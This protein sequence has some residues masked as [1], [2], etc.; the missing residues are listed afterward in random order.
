MQLALQFLRIIE[1]SFASPSACKLN[2]SLSKEGRKNDMAD[3]SGPRR[4]GKSG[5]NRRLGQATS[6][7]PEK[8][9]KRD[10]NLSRRSPS[11]PWPKGDVEHLLKPTLLRWKQQ[12][13]HMVLIYS[14][15]RHWRV[16]EM[17]DQMPESR[18]RRPYSKGDSS[19]IFR[20]F[21]PAA[22]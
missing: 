18:R 6:Y 20:M 10:T 22:I 21:Q 7:P 17:E 11:S 12:R 13:L 3:V 19:H 9:P 16:E 4:E 5:V 8:T 2:C 14:L 15:H 1:F